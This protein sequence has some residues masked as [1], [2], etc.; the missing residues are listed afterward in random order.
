MSGQHDY[1]TDGV[2]P[3]QGSQ[4]SMWPIVFKV[5]NL[6]PHLASRTDLLLLAGVIHGP[7]SPSDLSPY[8]MVVLD[9]MMEGMQGLTV[10]NPHKP[11]E[12]TSIRYRL[13]IIYG[14]YYLCFLLFQ[15]ITHNAWRRLSGIDQAPHASTRWRSLTF[16]LHVIY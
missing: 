15:F 2:N 5:L 9:E 4:Y 12:T 6:P 11:T 10:T 16:P 13:L 1:S 14:M 3:W 8:L 7:R